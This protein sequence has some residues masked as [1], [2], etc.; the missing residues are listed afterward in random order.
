MNGVRIYHNENGWIAETAIPLTETQL[1]AAI[2]FHK[3]VLMQRAKGWT[4]EKQESHG[5]LL[6]QLNEKTIRHKLIPA[7]PWEQ[8]RILY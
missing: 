5:K 7:Y 1:K 3:N 4:K 2:T 8:D 6:N